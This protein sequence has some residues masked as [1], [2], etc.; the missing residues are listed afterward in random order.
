MMKYCAFTICIN[1]VNSLKNSI[2]NIY[3]N[4]MKL[5]SLNF[6]TK[7][8]SWTKRTKDLIARFK[9]WEEM[10]TETWP[11]SNMTKWRK[12]WTIWCSTTAL[13]RRTSLRVPLFWRRPK[14]NLMKCSR[15]KMIDPGTKESPKMSCL[16]STISSNR[17]GSSGKMKVKR[18]CSWGQDSTPTERFFRSALES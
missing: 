12:K 6:R 2:W 11:S 15:E 5:L 1:P 3:K 8:I 17:P 9:Q 16:S 7:S 14:N 10:A 4:R 13:S 18:I